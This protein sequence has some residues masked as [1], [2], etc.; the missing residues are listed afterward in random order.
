[1]REAERT[2]GAIAELVGASSVLRPRYSTLTSIFATSSVRATAERSW[3]EKGVVAAR[4]GAGNRAACVA[5]ESVV[6]NHS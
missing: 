4:V 2:D 1:V 5:A 6:T 3:H